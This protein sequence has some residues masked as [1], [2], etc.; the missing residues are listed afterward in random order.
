MLKD[1][2]VKHELAVDV[3]HITLTVNEIASLVDGLAVLVNVTAIGL[4][5]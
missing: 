4:L 3:D 1:R 2:F 5:F